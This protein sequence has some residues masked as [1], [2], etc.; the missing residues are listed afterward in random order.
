[1]EDAGRVPGG[2]FLLVVPTTKVLY[3][4]RTTE[5]SLES[6][7]RTR[8]DI[9]YA[10]SWPVARHSLAGQAGRRVP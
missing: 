3:C 6:T 7:V 1:M 5:Y 2:R 4:T 8:D 10:M 9:S